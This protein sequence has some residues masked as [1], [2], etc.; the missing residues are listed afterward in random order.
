MSK[1]INDVVISMAGC[2]KP[3]VKKK[4]EKMRENQWRNGEMWRM[5]KA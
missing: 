3:G 5:R 2:Q 4:A 1:L